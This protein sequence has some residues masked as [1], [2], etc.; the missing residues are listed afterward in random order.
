MRRVAGIGLLA[1]AIVAGSLAAGCF[2][3]F[4]GPR[5]KNV[6][7][8]VVDTLRSNRL[9]C[10]GYPRATSPNID[11]L[12]ARGTVY[13]RNYSQA[14]WT[15]PSMISMMSGRS[16]VDEI[17]ALPASLPV[18]AESMHAA[19]FETAGFVANAV[20]GQAS[21]FARGFDVY[22]AAGNVH[23]GELA[24]RFAAW[25]D[26]RGRDKPFFAW[27]Q[28][29]DPHADIVPH[30]DNDP[31]DPYEPD[32]AHDVFHGPRVDESTVVPRWTASRSRVAELSPDPSTPGLD[33]SIAKATRDSNRY[34]G[35]VLAVDDGVGRILQALEKS[36]A[37]S[38]T[39][40][41]F[42][43]DHGEMLY[44]HPVQ[45]LIVDIVRKVND[46]KLPD[47]VLDLFGRGHRPWYF[48]DLWRTPLILA[49]P[50]IPEGVRR[51]SLS[52]NLDISATILDSVGL[53]AAAGH[54]GRSLFGGRESGRERVFAYGH[55]TAAVIETSGAKAIVHPPRMF[56]LPKD[57][58]SRVEVH[59]VAKDPLEEEDVAEAR[60]ADRDRLAKEIAEWRARSLHFDPSKVN[61]EQLKTLHKLGYTDDGK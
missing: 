24:D 39:L 50:G 33:V 29:I 2:G 45:P 5:P 61:P 9:H 27:V 14:C 56:L 31:H 46:G 28:F 12:A 40:V 17:K 11:R 58:P 21:G 13:E 54:E 15:L 47:G 8:I 18:L 59:D 32:A 52:A 22:E 26:A 1:V 3:S 25:S 48:E 30:A 10:Y 49:G 51:R 38:D 60:L 20:L 53:A 42:A 6:L 44:E 55:Q 35:E 57:A 19:G 34:D 37:L 23:A 16:V 41:L 7:L 4:R 36:G 43:A